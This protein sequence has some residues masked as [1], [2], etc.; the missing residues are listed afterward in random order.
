L[1][2]VS[3]L[4]D[5]PLLTVRSAAWTWLIFVVMTWYGTQLLLSGPAEDALFFEMFPQ[6]MRQRVNGLRLGLQE[7]GR[8]IAPLVGARGC[9]P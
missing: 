4:A 2:V 8:L 9:S 5:L 7:S 1:S 6:E 3:A